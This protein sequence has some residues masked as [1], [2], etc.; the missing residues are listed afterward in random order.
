MKKIMLS[1]TEFEAQST[2]Q[3]C[4]GCSPTEALGFDFAYAFQPIFD[5]KTGSVH[6]HEALVRG[7]EGQGSSDIL[8]RV[9][10]SNRYR[11]DQACRVRAIKE[12]SRLGMRERLSINFLPGAIYKPE[13]CIRT[14]IESAR[15]QG[16]ALDRII[17]EVSHSENVDDGAWLGQIFREYKSRG[18]LT[19]VDDFG[20]G[21]AGMSLLDELKPDIAKIDMS[22]ARGIDRHTLNQT[23]VRAMVSTCASLGVLLVAKGVETAAERDFFIDAGID[24]MQGHFFCKPIF[25]GLGQA[26]QG[27]LPTARLG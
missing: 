19:A 20:A 17:F 15:V 4:A 26:Q 14:T 12:A 21:Y 3:S 5:T 7:P 24:L 11:F 13:L 2:G 1:H 10:D 16:F 6:S 18:L 9:T 8:S 25:Q 22:L 23:L 27:S